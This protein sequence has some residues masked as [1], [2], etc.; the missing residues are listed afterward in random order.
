MPPL[1]TFK[2]ASAAV[3]AFPSL[4]RRLKNDY[5]DDLRANMK[6]VAR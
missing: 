4:P 3:K 1:F 5:E 6:K 2:C